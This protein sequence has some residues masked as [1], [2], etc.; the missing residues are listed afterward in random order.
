MTT[1][2]TGLVR[3]ALAGRLVLVVGGLL[4]VGAALRLVVQGDTGI[5]YSADHH[6]TVPMWAGWIPALVGIALV[7]LVPPAADP[8]WPDRIAPYREAVPLLLAGVAFAVIL[9]M[10]GGEPAYTLLK[11]TLLTGVPLG[12]L[13]RSRRRGAR[14]H[15]WRPVDAAH[16]YGPALP[17][18]AWLAL[19][20]AT[21]LA[22]PPGD[23]GRTVDPAVLVGV[24]V[25]GFAA[26]ALLEEVFYRRWLQS[27]W[28]SILGRWPAIALASLVWA[29]WHVGIQG[30]GRLGTDLASVAVNQGVLGLFLGYLWSRYRRMWPLL[31]VHGAVNSVPI[32]L[33]L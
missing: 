9:P 31:V 8:Q 24:L 25:V 32:L 33:G 10:L 6:D 4:F 21:P 23:F 29:A 18:L 27:R 22:V 3:R 17:V 13:L 12:V 14:W 11:V 5:R 16:R 7:R 1:D 20:Y 30:T 15:P 2:E 19:S 26:N 28:E